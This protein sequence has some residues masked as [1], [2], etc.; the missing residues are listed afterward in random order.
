[1]LALAELD[2]ESAPV[3]LD[4]PLWWRSLAVDLAGGGEVFDVSGH[5][6]REAVAGG[7][8]GRHPFLF[9]RDL[10]NAVLTTPPRLQFDPVRDR[11]LLRDALRG[12]IPERV[13]GRYAKSHFTPLLVEALGGPEGEAL[14]ATLAP[15]DAPIRGFVQ[16]QPLERLLAARDPRMPGG[17]ALQLWRLGM[18][19][20]WLRTL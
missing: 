1:L 8:D 12:Y 16:A 4:G 7:V 5:L 14:A 19:D 3:G 10:I 13:R 18:A 6:R 2:A 11:A 20:A 9:D 15:P 17:V